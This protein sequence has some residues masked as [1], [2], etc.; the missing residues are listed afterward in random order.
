[1]MS[2]ICSKPCV[3]IMKRSTRT[4][5]DHLVNF[6]PHEEIYWQLFLHRNATAHLIT[7]MSKNTYTVWQWLRTTFQ[8]KHIILHWFVHLFNFQGTI[9]WHVSSIID[10]LHVTIQCRYYSHIML[11]NKLS[12]TSSSSLSDHF[13]WVRPSPALLL[14]HVFVLYAS[15]VNSVY[16]RVS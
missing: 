1:M 11:I 9:S 7:I 4:H 10:F 13:W 15:L 14:S 6:L 2:H 3:L 12:V 16:I 8:E 5:M